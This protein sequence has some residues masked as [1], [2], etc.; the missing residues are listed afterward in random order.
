MWSCTVSLLE[1]VCF[2]KENCLQLKGLMRNNLRR[3]SV[4][5]IQQHCL[6][7]RQEVVVRV[8]C[9]VVYQCSALTAVLSF[10]GKPRKGPCPK[11]GKSLGSGHLA[12]A[13]THWRVPRADR[14][15]QNIQYDLSKKTPR[16]TWLGQ[17]PL[18]LRN[19]DTQSQS[20]PC[21]GRASA[22]SS[23]GRHI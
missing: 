8:C 12:Y 2:F 16:P 1:A 4:V 15:I 17:S 18:P 23:H 14:G 6:G 5:F 19:K 22:F 9:F 7:T 21:T 20:S 11:E 13:T 10:W 3:I